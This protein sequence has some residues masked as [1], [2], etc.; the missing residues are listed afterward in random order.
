MREEE[1]LR[2]SSAGRGG[3]LCLAASCGASSGVGASTAAEA[4]GRAAASA[5]RFMEF[6]ESDVPIR[7]PRSAAP[8]SVT[9]AVA[10][11]A[12][13]RRASLTVMEGDAA[14]L[15]RG[16]DVGVRTARDGDVEAEALASFSVEGRGTSAPTGVK[17]KLKIGPS[18]PRGPVAAVREAAPGACLKDEWAPKM[19]VPSR[20]NIM[21]W[22]RSTEWKFSKQVLR[23]ITNCKVIAK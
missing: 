18:E 3:S 16:E 6:S 15:G 5:P 21:F 7:A 2:L 19:G 23:S 11:R 17:S 22:A 20:L 10:S 13:P 4:R 14:K 9:P 1:R 12:E 8:S